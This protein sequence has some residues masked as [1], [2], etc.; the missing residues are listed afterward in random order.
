MPLVKG[1]FL[2]TFIKGEEGKQFVSLSLDLGASTASVIVGLGHPMVSRPD[3]AGKWII[4]VDNAVLGPAIDPE[5]GEQ[6]IGKSG[7]PISTISPATVDKPL[8]VVSIGPRPKREA[9][10][11]FA[12]AA[13]PPAPAAEPMEGA[14][15]PPADPTA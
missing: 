4:G 12:G 10:N 9:V 15:L 3:L 5:T 1:V 6:K 8:V 13:L 2:G 11:T 14:A 7:K